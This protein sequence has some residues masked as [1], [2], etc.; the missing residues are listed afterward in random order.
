MVGDIPLHDD[1]ILAL[2]SKIK[3]QP[4][5]FTEDQKLELSPEIRD[6]ITRMLVKDPS[7]R[8]TLNEIKVISS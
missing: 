7:L 4:V 3:T 1:N 8:I 6:L 5:E 2:Y